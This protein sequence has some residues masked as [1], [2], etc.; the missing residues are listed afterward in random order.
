MSAIVPSVDFGTLKVKELK[1]LCKARGLPVSGRKAELVSRLAEVKSDDGDDDDAGS[2]AAAGTVTSGEEEPMRY[3]W[4]WAA[5]QVFL[6]YDYDYYY[7]S[8]Y[9]YFFNVANLY[10][11]PSSV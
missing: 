9:Y 10:S 8:L 11:L 6:I 7:L 3:A 2:G 5:I 1:K 4:N